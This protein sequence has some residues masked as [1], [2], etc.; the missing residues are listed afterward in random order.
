[1]RS[2]GPGRILSPHP[3]LSFVRIMLLPLFSSIALA[4]L[5][6]AGS[7]PQVARSDFEIDIVETISCT[8]LTGASGSLVMKSLPSAPTTLP[9][10]GV[11]LSLVDN[12]LEEDDGNDQFIFESCTS[13][14][15]NETQSN[16]GYT[17]IYY[18]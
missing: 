15:M 13:T 7:V 12:V 8:P 1:M 4:A 17:A 5:V 2:L 16:D 10:G 14:F 11:S 9:D 18:G 6:A 3:L